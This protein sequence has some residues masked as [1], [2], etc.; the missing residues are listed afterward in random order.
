ME[1]SSLSE[2]SNFHQ[3]SRTPPLLCVCVCQCLW[4]A[5]L[6]R[7]L[8]SPN[9]IP[10]LLS[11]FG[12]CRLLARGGRG[13]SGG[14][15]G[16]SR[17]RVN[18]YR[19]FFADQM[20]WWRRL[21][22]WWRCPAMVDFIACSDI[23]HLVGDHQVSYPRPILMCLQLGV[24]QIHLRRG[25]VDCSSPVTRHTG[26]VFFSLGIK[27]GLSRGDCGLLVWPW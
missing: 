1:Y 24:L 16:L 23:C 25:C 5:S 21:P 17:T 15:S 26:T 19:S 9:R 10:S 27:V 14:R 7:K 13:G 20:R 22:L 11:I 8:S 6:R 2:A 4:T 12:G 3:S 18:P